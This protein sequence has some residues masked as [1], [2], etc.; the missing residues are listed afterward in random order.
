MHR[1]IQTALALSS[2][3]LAGPNLSTQTPANASG[4]WEGIIHMPDRELGMTL[5]LSRN[6][7][8]VW[9][10]SMSIPSSTS[11]DV[12]V[13]DIVVDAATV[14]FSAGLPGKTTFVGTL[15]ADGSGLSGKVSNREGSVG[16][17]LTRKGEAAVKVPP[18]S[19]PLSKE[20]EGTWEGTI[21][22]GGKVRRVLL[23]LSAAADGTAT[24]LLIS[25]DAG[26]IEIP[27]T[28]VTITEKELRLESR[29]ISGYYRG[30]AAPGG[31]IAG[32]WTQRAVTV[33]LTFK[34][35]Q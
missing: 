24:G 34:R 25:V 6:A 35:V 1:S 7:S 16:F 18:P 11:L 8:G 22:A 9:I 10:G 13:S 33:P 17:D 27:I 26:N 29:A 31:D 5:D 19:S 14:Q 2:L 15:N 28:T 4:H 21:D 30:T 32:E 23:K 3:L 12:P 20:F